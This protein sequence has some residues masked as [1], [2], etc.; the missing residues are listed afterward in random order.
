MKHLVFV[1][2]TNTNKMKSDG[3][4][5]AGKVFDKLTFQ[6]KNCSTYTDM[7]LLVGYVGV[8][9]PWASARTLTLYYYA[10]NF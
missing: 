5:K 3:E 9:T 6:H 4:R 2:V 1:I 8:H 7:R 10:S